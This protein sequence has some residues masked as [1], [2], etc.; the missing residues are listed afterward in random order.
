ML[1]ASL[2]WIGAVAVV[3][4]TGALSRWTEVGYLV[5]ALACALPMSAVP[6]ALALRR[7]ESLATSYVVKLNV[8]VALLVF[9]GTYVGTHYFFDLMGMRYAFPARLVL[10][11]ELVGK[12][13][14]HVPVFMYPL[15][16]AYFM[17]YYTA[18]VVAHRGLCRRLGL[19]AA[20]GAL[21]VAALSYAV[22]FAETFFMATDLMS[23]W[24]WYE[25]H[26]KMLALGS[27]GYAIYFV[28]GLPMVRGL[29][30]DARAPWP[31]SRVLVVALATS[32]LIFYG[33]ELWAKLVGAL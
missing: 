15:T 27:L 23:A 16:Q 7:G 20:S 13:G 14:M 26:G 9:F 17:T 22:A 5:F 28:I 31:M 25:K 10:E 19:G 2:V 18:L 29:D 32:M 8:F 3:V 12:S 30:E 4:S 6:I 33:L 11:A 24:F 1:W 21:L